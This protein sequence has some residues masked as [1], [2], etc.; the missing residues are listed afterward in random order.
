M[1]SDSDSDGMCV[2]LGGDGRVYGCGEGVDYAFRAW[3]GF[4]PLAPPPEAAGV[5]AGVGVEELV[6]DALLV[7]SPLTGP[8]AAGTFWLGAEAAPRCALEELAAAV[9]NFHT[10]GCEAHDFDPESSG[11]EW[12]G[13]PDI[14]RHVS[15][16][17]REASTLDMMASS[18]VASDICQ[19]VS[20][21]GS[22]VGRA[23][24]YIGT[25]TR[26]CA[27]RRGSSCTRTSAR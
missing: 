14:A 26:S 21:G 20:S 5:Q 24:R 25:R 19:A 27:S 8:G 11:V 7:D 10:V 9:F 12:W 23:W 1:E 15:D 4:V 3:T 2:M 6:R 22:R 18:D 16:T 13:L 17:H